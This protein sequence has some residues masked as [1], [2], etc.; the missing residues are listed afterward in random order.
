MAKC[1]ACGR[2]YDFLSGDKYNQCDKCSG[3]MASSARPV[4]ASDNALTEIPRES[5]RRPALVEIPP[6]TAVANFAYS[7]SIILGFLSLVSCGGMLWLGYTWFGFISLCS[8]LSL[9]FILM[10]LSELG[11]NVATLVALANRKS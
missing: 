11:N 10:F 1:T 4:A 6:R 8:G 2:E 3:E 5:L 7:L 9:A